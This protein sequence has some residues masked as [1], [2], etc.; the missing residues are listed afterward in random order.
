MYM[1]NIICRSLQLYIQLFLH[2]V[3][4]HSSP[5]KF[6]V[7]TTA[8]GSGVLGIKVSL[9]CVVGVWVYAHY[10]RLMELVEETKELYLKGAHSQTSGCH[11]RHKISTTHDPQP[12]VSVSGTEEV[13]PGSIHEARNGLETR[14]T[15]SEDPMEN[16]L[17]REA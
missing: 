13:D 16:I 6:M 14:H 2:T 4:H 8:A 9:S 15:E 17:S 11:E 3:K 10:K 1:Y 5:S 7:D 12:S